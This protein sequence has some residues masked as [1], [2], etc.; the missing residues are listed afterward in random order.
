MN[1]DDFSVFSPVFSDAPICTFEKRNATSVEKVCL[2]EHSKLA[3]KSGAR[4]S[5]FNEPANGYESEV[6]NFDSQ[7]FLKNGNGAETFTVNIFFIFVVNSVPKPIFPMLAF[8]PTE[9]IV[10]IFVG[11]CTTFPETL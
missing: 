1:S 7:R 8:G 2:P 6:E 4:I 3:P 11:S 10:D 9:Q 5:D